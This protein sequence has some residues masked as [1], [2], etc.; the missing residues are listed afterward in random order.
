MVDLTP[1]KI[2]QL[3]DGAI[4]GIDESYQ[5]SITTLSVSWIMEDTE[6]GI[7][8]YQLSVYA[9][10]QGSTAKFYP[11]QSPFITLH[12][13]EVGESG[14]LNCWTGNIQLSIGTLYT[15]RVVPVNRAKLSTIYTS[16]GIIPDNTPPVIDFLH[17]GTYGDESEELTPQE[18]A[19][20][21]CRC[22][23]LTLS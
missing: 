16:N 13:Q 14:T 15:V 8:E 6:S 17:I 4:S 19:V 12:P 23:L 2:I 7:S 10:V 9:R 18:N 1:P 5:T 22:Y 11:T 21:S 3:Y 20:S